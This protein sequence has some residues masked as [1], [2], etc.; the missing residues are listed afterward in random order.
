MSIL[1]WRTKRQVFYFGIFALIILAVVAGLVWYFWPEPTCFDDRKNGREEGIDCGGPCTP[2]MGEIKDLS[3]SWARF[4][5]NREGFYDVAA[6]IENPNLFGGIPSVRYQFKLYDV[7]NVLIAVR[8]GNT[9]IN[10][11]ERR[12]I[13]ESN[14][15]MG[16]RIPSRAY[17]EFDQQKNW[18][19]IEKEK[20]FLSVIK[21]DF[22]NFP[23]PRLSAEIKNDS[24]FDVK[25]VLVAAV[26]YDDTGNVVGVSFTKIDLIK[27]E[28]SRTAAFTWT[29]PF[30]KEPA[31]TEVI[32]T[33]NLTENNK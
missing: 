14:L 27:A 33:T 13:F 11:N 28:S 12:I 6:L 23:F 4:F 30:E 19:Y 29:Q 32:P 1:P 7:N 2:C 9:F 31:T 18:K 24:L 15:S 22:S 16:S 17:I 10:P 26:L 5:K 3:V 21:K 25:D 8:E 20:S